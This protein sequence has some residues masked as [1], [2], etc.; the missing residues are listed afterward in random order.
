MFFVGTPIALAG[1]VLAGRGGWVSERARRTKIVYDA[2]VALREAGAA[3]FRPGD[4]AEQLRPTDTP[5]GAW[6][7]RGEL[8]N[9]E[10]LGLVRCDEETA[11]WQLTQSGEFDIA[12]AKALADGA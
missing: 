4:I 6:E 8:G 5:F 7:V 10:R 11:T 9:L 1:S 12:A 3:V 2:A